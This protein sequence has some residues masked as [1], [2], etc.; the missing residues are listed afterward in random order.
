MSYISR[1]ASSLQHRSELG[2]SW[3]L[4]L[5]AKASGFSLA[6]Y[7]EVAGH[8][9]ASDSEKVREVNG[10]MERESRL[11]AVYKKPLVLLGC[12]FPHPNHPN[13]SIISLLPLRHLI[14]KSSFSPL[15]VVVASSLALVGAKM[16]PT[17][18]PACDV[19]DQKSTNW[20][21]SQLL[22]AKGTGNVID[23]KDEDFLQG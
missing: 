4:K 21:G 5:V 15:L 19:A 12:P 9:N 7:S 13:L 22:S 2:Y 18:F 10:L 11:C 23:Y 20:G 8:T 6:P 17:P 3:W 14:M 1:F 16:I